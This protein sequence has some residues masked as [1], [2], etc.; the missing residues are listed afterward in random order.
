ML[1]FDEFIKSIETTNIIEKD[2]YTYRLN[3]RQLI[4]F[5]IIGISLILL[6]GLLV[7]QG[8]V[9]NK[10][11]CYFISIVVFYLAL[12]NF[13]NIFSYRIK[14]DKIE[15]SMSG[16]GLNLSFNDI[17]ECKLKEGIIGKVKYL[18]VY[19]R[20]VTKDKKE[21]IIPLNMNKKLEFVIVVKKILQERFWVEK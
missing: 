16:M 4:L 7:Y 21:I 10:I 9:E 1:F 12:K 6:G 2:R 5:M 17:M 18:Q 14:I 20:I 8:Y 11:V 13:K 3:N 15:N 19:L